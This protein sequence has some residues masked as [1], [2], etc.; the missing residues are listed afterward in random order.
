MEVMQQKL[1]QAETQIRLQ[2]QQLA[3]LRSPGSEEFQQLSGDNLPGDPALKSQVAE[4]ESDRQALEEELDSVR[5]RAVDMAHTI[6][7]QKKQMSEEHSQWLAELRQL[8]RILDK[9]SQ[10]ITQQNPMG[11]DPQGH[12]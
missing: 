3:E 10:W 4:L 1:L 6:A 11:T 9:Q 5:S 7:E 12:R 2:H 8:R